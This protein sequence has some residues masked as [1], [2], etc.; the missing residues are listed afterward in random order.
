MWTLASPDFNGMFAAIAWLLF[1][2]V[3]IPIAMITFV[4]VAVILLRRQSREP[5]RDRYDT[6]DRRNQN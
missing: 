6:N 4:V 1:V 3:V 2:Y 5:N